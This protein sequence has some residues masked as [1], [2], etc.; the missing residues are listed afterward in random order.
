MNSSEREGLMGEDGIP[1]KTADGTNTWYG[2]A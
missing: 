1:E 2:D